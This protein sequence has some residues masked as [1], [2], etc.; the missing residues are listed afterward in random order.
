MD[1]FKR[2]AVYL[3]AGVFGVLAVYF[4]CATLAG[5]ACAVVV[6]GQGATPSTYNNISVDANGALLVGGTTAPAQG[7]VTDR[8]GTITLGGT[9]QTIMAANANRKLL[10]G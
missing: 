6:Q 5:D 10:S 9:A 4:I 8:S 3:L 7:T 1:R 2:N